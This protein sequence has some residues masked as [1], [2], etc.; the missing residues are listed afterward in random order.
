MFSEVRSAQRVGGDRDRV[1]PAAWATPWPAP[2][3][4]ALRIRTSGRGRS[5]LRKGGCDRHRMWNAAGIHKSS[6][7]AWNSPLSMKTARAWLSSP[8]AT[9]GKSACSLVRSILGGLRPR[10]GRS[11]RGG[12]ALTVDGTW[13]AWRLHGEIR[14]ANRSDPVLRSQ[15]LAITAPGTTRACGTGADL[16]AAVRPPALRKRPH[17]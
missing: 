8:H 5:N 16:S 2:G 11:V 7:V 1:R 6:G 15:R 4:S 17:A 13:T 10:A 3:P 12:I 9:I 14:T